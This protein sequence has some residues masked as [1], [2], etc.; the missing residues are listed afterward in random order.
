MFH[1]ASQ[2]DEDGWLLYSFS[3]PRHGEVG[4]GMKPSS[5]LLPGDSHRQAVIWSCETMTTESCL[6]SR[7]TP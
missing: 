1:F 4:E 7:Y 3:D 2:S 5:P 6:G